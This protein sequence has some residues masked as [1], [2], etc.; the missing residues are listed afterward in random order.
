MQVLFFLSLL[1]L[2][3]SCYYLLLL[4]CSATA[5]HLHHRLPPTTW[6]RNHQHFPL[7]PATATTTTPPIAD[8]VVVA[9]TL[10][11]VSPLSAATT[12]YGGNHLQQTP[13][14]NSHQQPLCSKQPLNSL[15]QTWNNLN[16]LNFWVLMIVLLIITIYVIKT[17]AI[18]QFLLYLEVLDAMVNEQEH[19][20]MI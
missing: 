20:Q 4:L 16:S 11:A 5:S 10:A 19:D 7:R 15:F 18:M 8:V 6:P 3:D 9:L 2:H 1:S 14:P 12:S 13:N 17:D